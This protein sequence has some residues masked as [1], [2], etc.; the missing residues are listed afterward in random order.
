MC[1]ALLRHFW[2]CDTGVCRPGFCICAFSVAVWPASVSSGIKHVCVRVE[3]AGG[4]LSVR[5][6]VSANECSFRIRAGGAGQ[7]PREAD[8]VGRQAD[9]LAGDGA[10]DP[11]VPRGA[12][13]PRLGP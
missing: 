6:R 5:V 9:G 1:T 10:G 11:N 12:Q 13:C 3:Q 4:A 8:L 2:A 7:E